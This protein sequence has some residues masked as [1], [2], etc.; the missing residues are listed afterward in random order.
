MIFE[1]P[2]FARAQWLLSTYGTRKLIV[3]AQIAWVVRNLASVV[4]ETQMGPLVLVGK[5]GLVFWGVDLQK[6]EVIWVPGGYIC[7]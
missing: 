3:A 6:Q 1:L 4:L 5:F 2:I 7:T